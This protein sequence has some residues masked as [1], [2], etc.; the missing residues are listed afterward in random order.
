MS[1]SIGLFRKLGGVLNDSIGIAKL[2]EVVGLFVSVGLRSRTP[3]ERLW[4]DRFQR[5]VVPEVG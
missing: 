4:G 2:T 3:P 1:H 5:Y